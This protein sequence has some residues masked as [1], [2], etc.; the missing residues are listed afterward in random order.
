[1]P[2]SHLIAD[3]HCWLKLMSH[4][5]AWH[6]WVFQTKGITSVPFDLILLVSS[7]LESLCVASR[8]RNCAAWPSDWAQHFVAFIIHFLLFVCWPVNF[9][10]PT[11][12]P[13]CMSTPYMKL[14]NRQAM[15]NSPILSSQWTYY[16]SYLMMYFWMF[17]CFI[18]KPIEDDLI[19]IT[20]VGTGSGCSESEVQGALIKVLR[21]ELNLSVSAQPGI[22][23]CTNDLQSSANAHQSREKKSNLQS[24]F[25]SLPRKPQ[26]LGRLVVNRESLH[27]WLQKRVVITRQ[28]SGGAHRYI[29][30]SKSF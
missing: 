19:I 28:A 29:A 26:V 4:F 24:H 13:G 25:E 5:P 10:K 30:D 17:H 21:D 27:S 14:P 16:V 20:G 8:L 3:Y 2:L 9:G 6:Y 11:S 23:L 22:T 1:M 7:R 15:E 18:G 12:F